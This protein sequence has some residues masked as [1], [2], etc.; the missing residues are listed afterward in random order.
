MSASCGKI[1]YFGVQQL[2]FLLHCLDL[3]AM[4]MAALFAEQTL[5]RSCSE[6]SLHDMGKDSASFQ[7]IADSEPPKWTAHT[8]INGGRT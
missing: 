5:V 8:F 6:C 1:N 3:K 7:T 2:A 4:P